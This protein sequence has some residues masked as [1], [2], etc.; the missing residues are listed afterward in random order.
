[1]GGLNCWGLNQKSNFG[2]EPPS[3]QGESWP[4]FS[5]TRALEKDLD[6]PHDT[7][8]DFRSIDPFGKARGW[9][10]IEKTPNFTSPE[11]FSE[12]ASEREFVTLI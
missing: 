4:V 3:P 9:M 10:V 1:M 6:V 5:R 11:G 2:S 7:R 12:G 8:H